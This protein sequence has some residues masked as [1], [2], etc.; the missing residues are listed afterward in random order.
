MF[1][2]LIMKVLRE[3]MGKICKQ[4]KTFLIVFGAGVIVVTAIFSF[5]DVLALIRVGDS[6]GTMSTGNLNKGLVGYWQMDESHFN[7]STDR[8]DDISGYGN[9]GTNYG[10]TFTEDRMGNSGGAMSFGASSRIEIPFGESY[11]VGSNNLTLSMWV[12]PDTTTG[13]QMFAAFGTNTDSRR[14]YFAKYNDKWDMGIRGSGW[15][16]GVTPV[17]TEWTHI[18]IVFDSLINKATMYVNGEFS[19]D[20]NYTDYSLL[21]NL[22]IAVYGNNG[23]QFYGEIDDVRIYNR[24]I[25]EDEIKSLYRSYKPKVSTSNL[26][27]GLI[28]DMPLT[29]KYTKDETL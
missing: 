27:K 21:A 13:S 26:N 18:T 19:L 28:L 4:W 10:A 9:H 11:D 8:V 2:Y 15:G 5:A 1:K 12:K 7:S 29:L 22:K 14:A 23:Y 16:S 6:T 20:K 24:A 25:S 3:T 17:T